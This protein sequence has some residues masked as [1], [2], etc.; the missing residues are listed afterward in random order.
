MLSPYHQFPRSFLCLIVLICGV[1]AIAAEWSFSPRCDSHDVVQ[2]INHANM[3]QQRLSQICNGDQSECV[4]NFD[5]NRMWSVLLCQLVIATS[6]CVPNTC[7]VV[8]HSLSGFLCMADIKQE[9][10]WMLHLMLDSYSFLY[11]LFR[12]QAF[13]K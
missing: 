7:L 9:I 11:S 12:D 2:R 3:C 10:P 6:N 8:G 13:G 4:R 5:R 1:H